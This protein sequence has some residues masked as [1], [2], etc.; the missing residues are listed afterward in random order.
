MALQYLQKYGMQILDNIE[1]SPQRIFNSFSDR[2]AP[3]VYFSVDL[4]H[5]STSLK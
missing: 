3:V 4:T 5:I 1:T 2:S